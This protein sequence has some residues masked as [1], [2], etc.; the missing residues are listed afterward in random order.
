MREELVRF[1]RDLGCERLRP[2]CSRRSQ[3]RRRRASPTLPMLAALPPTDTPALV[4]AAQNELRRIG[5]FA[6]E[7][8]GKF[9]D[10][11]RDAVRR[12]GPSAASPWTTSRSARC[13]SPTSRP[14]TKAC[15]RSTVGAA[16]SKRAA[17]ASPRRLR[18]AVS[19]RPSPS[20]AS[21]RWPVH[22][23]RPSMVRRSTNPSNRPVVVQPTIIG[24]FGLAL[25]HPP[26]H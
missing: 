24:G 25:R 5:C 21:V 14:R 3:A 10:K 8:D 19:S 4:R 11:T 1:E 26:G 20:G 16:R 22:R 13:W 18:R 12:F 9:T 6:G 2:W 15:A 23:S 7:N 17:V